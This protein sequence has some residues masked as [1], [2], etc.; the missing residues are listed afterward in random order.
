MFDWIMNGIGGLFDSIIFW[1]VF[2]VVII[3]VL[4]LAVR[5]MNHNYTAGKGMFKNSDNNLEKDEKMD[6]S[7]YDY[8]D[9]KGNMR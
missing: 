8:F 3:L 9:D 6:A 5:N 7:D 2:V 1:L 4:A